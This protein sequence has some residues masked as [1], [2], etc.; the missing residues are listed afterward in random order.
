MFLNW[1]TFVSLKISLKDLMIGMPCSTYKI[2]NLS[3]VFPPWSRSVLRLSPPQDPAPVTAVQSKARETQHC[4]DLCDT[5]TNLLEWWGSC[6]ESGCAG[7][8]PIHIDWVTVLSSS[9]QVLMTLCKARPEL[10]L[11]PVSSTSSRCSTTRAR[12]TLARSNSNPGWE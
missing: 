2:C 1:N 12:N 5:D 10:T 9:M 4:A 7:G 6:K 11:W 8:G 3:P